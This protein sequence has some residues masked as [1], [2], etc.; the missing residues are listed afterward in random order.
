ME[1]IAFGTDGVRGEAGSWPMNSLG[2]LRIG[3]GVGT[4]LK[5][6]FA[7]PCVLIGR[8]TRQSGDTPFRVADLEQITHCFHCF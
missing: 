1:P 4:F 6:K 2:A 3:Q 7:S 8:D 5:E